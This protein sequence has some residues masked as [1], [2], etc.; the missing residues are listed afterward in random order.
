MARYL[1]L[2]TN[3]LAALTYNSIRQH[4]DQ[5]VI[6]TATPGGSFIGTALE[7]CN[8]QTIVLKSGVVWRG[9]H[10]EVPEMTLNYPICA[11]E[12]GVFT[13]HPTLD[14]SYGLIDMEVNCGNKDLSVFIINPRFWINIPKKDAGVLAKVKKLRI[15]RYMNHKEDVLVAEVIPPQQALYYGV[16]GT[17]AIGLNYVGTLLRG[18]VKVNETVAYLFDHLEPYTAG[19]DQA[20]VDAITILANKTRSR[21]GKLRDG[22]AEIN[23]VSYGFD[24]TRR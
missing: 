14:H 8:E 16:L 2:E 12:W 19:L 10:D 4:D 17:S 18:D 5:A 7:N 21:V 11:S 1:V 23:G 24:K 3:R 6:T 9:A 15:P 22:L 13:D 20:D